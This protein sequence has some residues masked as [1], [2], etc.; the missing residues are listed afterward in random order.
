MAANGTG[1]QMVS[2]DN[3]TINV[4]ETQD[5]QATAQAVAKKLLEMQ[6]N[7]KQRS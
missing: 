4:Y 7:W 3:I 1:G 6:R 2:S 5:A